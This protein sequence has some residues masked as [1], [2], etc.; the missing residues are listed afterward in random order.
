MLSQTDSADYEK[1]GS[2]AKLNAAKTYLNQAWKEAAA[3]VSSDTPTSETPE[4]LAVYW[5]GVSSEGHWNGSKDHK[6]SP[7]PS[8]KPFHPNRHAGLL[9]QELLLVIQTHDRVWSDHLRQ[10]R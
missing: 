7:D 6:A 5:L 9:A 1:L 4:Q 2:Q 8:Y 10:T 3:A